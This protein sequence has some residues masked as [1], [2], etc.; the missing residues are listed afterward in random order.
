[1]RVASRNAL[2]RSLL[3]R[4]DALYEMLSLATGM[5]DDF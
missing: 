5:M 2:D 3:Q 1:M 4:S